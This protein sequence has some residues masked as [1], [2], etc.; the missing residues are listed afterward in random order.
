[1]ARAPVKVKVLRVMGVDV[2][3][4]VGLT[5]APWLPRKNLPT[6]SDCNSNL[7]TIVGISLF[8]LSVRH[9]AHPLFHLVKQLH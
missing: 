7:W 9:N 3:C 8:C 1:M 2:R 4:A 5:E 6:V